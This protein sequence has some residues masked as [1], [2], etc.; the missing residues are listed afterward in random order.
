MKASIWK[1]C[2]L[3]KLFYSTVSQDTETL[4]TWVGIVGKLSDVLLDGAVSPLPAYPKAIGMSCF[5]QM[6]HKWHMYS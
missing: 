3:P 4:S 2:E 1:W 6:D 5:L